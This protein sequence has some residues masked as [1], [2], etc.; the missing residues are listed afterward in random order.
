MN[1]EEIVRIGIFKYL[2]TGIF[3]GLLKYITY[4]TYIIKILSCIYFVYLSSIYEN[5]AKSMLIY[6]VAIIIN[7]ANVSNIILWL[8]K[9]IITIYFLVR[10]AIDRTIIPYKYQAT[11][12]PIVKDYKKY[13]R[14][15]HKSLLLVQTIMTI[16]LGTTIVLMNNIIGI[17]IM[18]NTIYRIVIILLFDVLL[19]K[20]ETCEI[21]N[22]IIGA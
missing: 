14:K 17:N 6:S 4:M 16:V 19:L 3:P 15:I 1:K 22:S 12:Y 10:H 9:H 8:Y 21:L 11:I 2:K 13:N 5:I 20:E 7:Y 18:S